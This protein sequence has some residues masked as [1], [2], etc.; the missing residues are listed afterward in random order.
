MAFFIISTQIN[1]EFNRKPYDEYIEQVKP[2][3]E[4]YGGEYIVRSEKINYL[5]NQWK[6]DRLIIIKFP[7]KEYIDQC[8]S[9]SE[10]KTIE[11]LR[12]ETVISNAIIVEEM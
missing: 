7:S 1:N 4:K 9:S 8:F 5:N 2:I 11:K 6:P 12:I 3:V 10:Y